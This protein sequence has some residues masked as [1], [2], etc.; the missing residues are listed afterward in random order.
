MNKLRHHVDFQDDF[1]ESDMHPTLTMINGKEEI[2]E[3]FRQ[4]IHFARDNI[5]EV[6]TCMGI[7]NRNNGGEAYRYFCSCHDGDY[8]P[9]NI[10][11][12]SEW[13][14]HVEIE[15]MPWPTGKNEEML[16][17]KAINVCFLKTYADSGNKIRYEYDFSENF[18]RSIIGEPQDR[19][20]I[21]ENLT[22]RLTMMQRE[23]SGDAGINDEPLRSSGGSIRRFRVTRGARVHYT[24]DSETGAILFEEFIPDSRHL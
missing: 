22:K 15:N 6:L 21:I 2:F 9:T 4:I 11:F 17:K 10:N 23:A 18:M 7:P 16:L 19:T 5:P 13:I 14:E 12:S 24:Y 8:L 20:N 1:P 3:H